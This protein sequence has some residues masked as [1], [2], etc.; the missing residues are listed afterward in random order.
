MKNEKLLIARTR[1]SWSQRKAAAEIGVDHKTYLNWENGITVPQPYYRERLCT[2]FG[3]TLEELGYGFLV[4]LVAQE[5]HSSQA[6]VVENTPEREEYVY[7]FQDQKDWS[8]W[9]GLKLAHILNVIRLWSRQNE[10][11]VGEIQ[12]IV[13]QE[14]KMMDETLEQFHIDEQNMSRRQ[15]L[16]TVAA[17]PTMLLW[18]TGLMADAVAEE[19]LSQ[20]AAS[21]T[22]CWHL[23]RGKGLAAVSEIVPKFAPVLR[24]LALRPSRYQQAAARLATQMSIL[25]AILAMHSLNVSA[26]EA[27]C[28]DTIRYSDI[29]KDS[30]LQAAARMYL[31]YTL[32]FCYWPRKPENA[33][34]IFQ[35]ALHAL[36]NEESLIRSDILMGIA[37][38]YAQCKEERQA[39]HYIGLAQEH[40]PTY[41]E[42]DQSFIY[43]ECGLTTLYQWE[44]KMYLELSEHYADRGY[45]TKASDAL[46]R[47]IGTSTLS[48][49]CTNETII[50][51]ADAARILG[52]LDIYTTSLRT[53]AQMALDIGSKKRYTEALI[54]YQRTPQNWVNEPQVRTL[55]RD[56]FKQLPRPR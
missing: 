31:G 36:D 19:F 20:S 28:H 32:S 8:T 14:I 3:A 7:I 41:P 5:P 49:R 45:Q 33:I 2:V 4:E 37:E 13:D 29:A 18:Q 16:I 21:I 30:R 35:Q 25:Q 34:P 47:S 50:Y 53:A 22:A 17:L 10:D 44:G 27:Y 54:V 1:K 12:A 23:L 6:T 24:T 48:E 56:I 40:F 39:L 11:F 9:F 52:E 51:Q 42:H 26:R 55:A 38:A 43:A 15:A 46:M